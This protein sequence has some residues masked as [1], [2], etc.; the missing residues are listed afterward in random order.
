MREDSEIEAIVRAASKGPN[1]PKAEIYRKLAIETRDKFNATY[2]ELDSEI[3]SIELLV[4]SSTPLSAVNRSIVREH[5]SRAFELSKELAHLAARM[6]IGG[7]ESYR[8]KFSEL[9]KR[10]EDTETSSYETD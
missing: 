1:D 10:L 3:D 6:A 5:K 7:N 9:F 4:Y 2:D 8:D